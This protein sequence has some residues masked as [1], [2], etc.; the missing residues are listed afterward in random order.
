MD[1]EIK[2][3]MAS[4]DRMPESFRDQVKKLRDFRDRMRSAGAVATEEQFA[5]PLMERLESPRT[6]G[7]QV[8]QTD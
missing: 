7:F 4:F 6:R 3:A 2:D 1:H 8:F 5:T